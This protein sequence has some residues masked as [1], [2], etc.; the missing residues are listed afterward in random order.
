MIPN[1]NLY[2]LFFRTARHPVMHCPKPKQIRSKREIYAGSIS[3]VIS[4]G[5]LTPNRW[6]WRQKI[7]NLTQMQSGWIWYR[8]K[9]M[10]YG[11]GQMDMTQVIVRQCCRYF[12]CNNMLK[13]QQKVSQKRDLKLWVPVIYTVTLLWRNNTRVVASTLHN[14]RTVMVILIG[15]Y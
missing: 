14:S 12:R 3:A 2:S 1:C 5:F 9:V 10:E 8:E 11:L 6:N 4:V 15:L 13:S 7:S